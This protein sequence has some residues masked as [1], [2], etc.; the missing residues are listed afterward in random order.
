MTERRKRR[1][2]DPGALAAW[3]EQC[4][5]DLPPGIPPD[6]FEDVCTRLDAVDVWGCKGEK[7]SLAATKA[8]IAETDFEW[9][10]EDVLRWLERIGGQCDCT[11]R[12]KAHKRLLRLIRIWEDWD[13]GEPFPHWP[14][15]T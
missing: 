6:F 9:R 1:R 14:G 3:A 2:P 10:R 15:G 5:N 11:V 4:R 12:S 7:H 8:F 13:A